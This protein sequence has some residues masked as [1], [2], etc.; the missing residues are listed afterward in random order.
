MSRKVCIIC[1]YYV[2]YRYYISFWVLCFFLV[3]SK[4]RITMSPAYLYVLAV[5]LGLLLNLVSEPAG[6]LHAVV[7]LTI[8]PEMTAAGLR[9]A[10]HHWKERWG[11]LLFWLTLGLLVPAVAVYF[12]AAGLGME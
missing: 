8:I 3:R 1:S 6:V 10:W 4:E 5:I 9:S 11:K 12:L 2:D 7:A